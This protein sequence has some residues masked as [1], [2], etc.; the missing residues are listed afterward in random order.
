MRVATGSEIFFWLETGCGGGFQKMVLRKNI[1]IK[2]GE[3]A[4]RILIW[5]FQDNS[6]RPG[7]FIDI[8]ARC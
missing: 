3:R 5:R 4:P 8:R 6:G 7:D 2:E 1:L